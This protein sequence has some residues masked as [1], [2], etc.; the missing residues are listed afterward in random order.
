MENDIFETIKDGFKKNVGNGP[1]TLFWWDMWLDGDCLKNIFP[2]L[3]SVTLQQDKFIAN[4]GVWNGVECH[5]NLEWRR[6]LFEWEIEQLHDLESLIMGTV[7]RREVEDAVVWCFRS[8]NLLSI[9][10]FVMQVSL[11]S[12]ISMSLYNTQEIWLGV[13][14]PRAEIL[15]WLLMLGKLNTKD[16]L[17]RFH[18]INEDQVQCPFCSC[19]EE[20]I[21]HLFFTYQFSWKVWNSCLAW[22][23]YSAVLSSMSVRI[24]YCL[25]WGQVPRFPEKSLDFIILYSSLDFMV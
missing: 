16:R 10:S 1:K 6:P 11:S 17:R 20:S 22:W 24:F 15:T 12:S 13:A 3:F 9:K 7:D 19:V 5:W 14:P 8:N 25:D 18:I 21:N 23:G 2:R 4:M